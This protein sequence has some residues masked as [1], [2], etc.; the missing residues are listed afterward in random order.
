ML[1][2]AFSL[3]NFG[4][5]AERR[6]MKLPYPLNISRIAMNGNLLFPIPNTHK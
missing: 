2:K 5:E 1:P 3:M 6:K 4:R